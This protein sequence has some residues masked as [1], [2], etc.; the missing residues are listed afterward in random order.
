MEHL[1]HYVIATCY[2]KILCYIIHKTLL[3]PFI[4]SLGS[5]T[6]IL[7][8]NSVL[9]KE[10]KSTE[11]TNDCLLANFV[12]ASPSFRSSIP[13]IV[14]QA[15][16]AADRKPFQLYTKSTC[17][18][19]HQLLLLLLTGFQKHLQMLSDLSNVDNPNEFGKHVAAVLVYRYGLQALAN[20]NALRMHLENI[21]HLLNDHCRSESNPMPKVKRE[22]DPQEDVELEQDVELKAVHF[23][24]TMNGMRIPLW[25]SY[26]DWLRLMVVHFDA[27]NILVLHVSQPNFNHN[28]SIKI[29]VTPP[30]DDALLPWKDLLNDPKLFPTI[31]QPLSE[32]DDKILSFFEKATSSN[33]RCSLEFANAA[34]AS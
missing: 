4:K 3:L 19:F 5:V 34:L 17:Q 21:E 23:S 32:T 28:I 18:Q 13:D 7:F 26:C 11:S 16:L 15:K 33:F 29:L 2:P 22:E 10:P 12:F 31:D 27:V 9:H 8:D 1:L 24:T 6:D 20:S 30:V 14:S 25:M